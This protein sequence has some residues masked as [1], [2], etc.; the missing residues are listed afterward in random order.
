MIA[1][2]VG[3]VVQYHP[4]SLDGLCRASFYSVSDDPRAFYS[5]L[6]NI[7]LNKMV[8]TH[9]KLG[10]NEYSVAQ[11]APSGLRGLAESLGRP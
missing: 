9:G 1:R 5:V 10:K 8:G 11:H 3:I 6:R 7:N 2:Y 4:L